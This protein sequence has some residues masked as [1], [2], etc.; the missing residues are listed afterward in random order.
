MVSPADR[1]RGQSAPRPAEGIGRFASVTFDCADPAN[2]VAWWQRL[3]G[4]RAHLDG[5]NGAH[6]DAPGVRL[7]FE[8]VPE[9]KITK[10][11]VHIDIPSRDLRWAV[12]RARR[13]GATPALDIYAGDRW[14]V[15]RDPEGKEFCILPP[16]A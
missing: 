3:L 5:E 7:Y 10:N 15:M 1:H 16:E 14:R 8:R 2:L 13:L 6:L 11:R 9:P 4:G 12:E